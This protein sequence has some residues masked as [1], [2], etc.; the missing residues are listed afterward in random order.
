[1]PAHFSLVFV[2]DHGK[3]TVGRL[4]VILPLS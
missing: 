2:F 3:G 1:M 4:A